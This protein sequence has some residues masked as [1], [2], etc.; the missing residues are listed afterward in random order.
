MG[1][2]ANT[3]DGWAMGPGT[4]SVYIAS[5][6][7]GEHKHGVPAVRCRPRP[8]QEPCLLDPAAHNLRA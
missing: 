7:Q 5:Y 4:T 3:T 2:H 1:E 8:L 6:D